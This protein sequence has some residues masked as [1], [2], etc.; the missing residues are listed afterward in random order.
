MKNLLNHYHIDFE[1]NTDYHKGNLLYYGKQH[2]YLSKKSLKRFSKIK[3]PYDGYPAF[4]FLTD[5]AFYTLGIYE[6]GTYENGIR[7]A[8]KIGLFKYNLKERNYEK[9]QLIKHL[10]TFDILFTKIENDILYMVSLGK[11]E[12]INLKNY[13][14][15]SFGFNYNDSSL[16]NPN[17]NLYNAGNGNF[18]GTTGRGN[19]QK[20]FRYNVTSNKLKFLSNISYDINHFF[21]VD[22]CRLIFTEYFRSNRVLEYVI[23]ILTLKIC[24]L[25]HFQEVEVT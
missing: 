3:W 16:I 1:Y 24:I 18:Y 25:I 7:S 15:K 6:N 5:T 2:F 22:N 9:V 4:S 23:M 21:R 10:T 17:F 20:L 14:G 19:N 8:N 13:K 11:I 12:T